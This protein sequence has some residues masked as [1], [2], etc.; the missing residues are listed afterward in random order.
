MTD[1]GDVNHEPQSGWWAALMSRESEERA[2]RWAPSLLTL[3]IVLSG[4]LLGYGQ[5]QSQ[6]ANQERRLETIERKREQDDR[7]TA[8][9]NAVLAAQLASIQALLRTTSE[10]V[11]GLNDRFDRLERHSVPYNKDLRP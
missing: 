1:A 9:A 4:A 11:K 10:A 2:A 8:S 6:I 3:A 5:L 7:D